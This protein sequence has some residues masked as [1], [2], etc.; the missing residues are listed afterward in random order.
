M[1]LVSLFLDITLRSHSSTAAV[2]WKLGARFQSNGCGSIT[3]D[4]NLL[5]IALISWHNACSKLDPTSLSFWR[6]VLSK[7]GKQSCYNR[8]RQSLLS[9]F[10]E[11]EDKTIFGS[12]V[13]WLR[14]TTESLRPTLIHWTRHQCPH[15]IEAVQPSIKISKHIGAATSDTRHRALTISLLLSGVPMTMCMSILNIKVNA[16]NSSSI[17]RNR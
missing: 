1:Y 10:W 4:T 12:L 13:Q 14:S 2:D 16:H 15:V 8:D 11:Q 6:P 9:E 3:C 17:V 7:V 5:K